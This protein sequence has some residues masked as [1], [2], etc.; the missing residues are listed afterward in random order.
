MGNR[1]E[2]IAN[3]EAAL[4]IY[5]QIESPFASS[6]RDKLAKWRAEEKG[7]PAE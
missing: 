2:A 1:A 3:V 4:R 5:K 6:V 7:H